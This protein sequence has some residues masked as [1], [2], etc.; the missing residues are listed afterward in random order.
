MDTLLHDTFKFESL[1]PANQNDNT[2]K[3]ESQIQLQPFK[4]KKNLIPLEP[5]KPSNLKT[6][7]TKVCMVCSKPT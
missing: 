6:L 2:A 4:L 7:C 1:G 5:T 3:T